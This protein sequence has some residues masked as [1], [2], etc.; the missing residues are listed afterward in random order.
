MAVEIIAT[1][2]S[3]GE[4]DITN[5]ELYKIISNF[6]IEVAKNSL[7]RKGVDLTNASE[8]AIFSLWVQQISG[9]KSRPFM[10]QA[11]EKKL[12]VE[13]LAYRASEQ[14]ITACGIEREKIEQVIFSTYSSN[15]VMPSPACTLINLLELPNASAITMN[16]AC[17]GFLDALIDAVI[18]IESGYFNTILVVASEQL[19]NKMNF[20]DPKSSVIFSD[21]AGCVIVSKTNKEGKGVLSFASGTSF[22]EQIY[23]ERKDSIYFNSGPLVKRNAVRTMFS[24]SEQSL[25]DKFSFS[26]I[27][28][29]IPHQANLRIIDEFE[30]KINRLCEES[31]SPKVIK[32]IEDL[33]NLS[34][35]TLPVALDLLV[36]KDYANQLSQ[37]NNKKMIFVSVGGGYTF[38]SLL[39]QF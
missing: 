22:S 6:E 2:S 24:I 8:E 36:K 30:R 18:R 39:Y 16:G 35:A 20:N 7:T 26:E 15:R 13:E 32:T 5:E 31:S 33:G 9:I 25:K 27:D 23:M 37:L 1:G 4:S 14:A 29:I 21:G 3:V 11:V 19:S 34:S 12:E 17:S 10:K 38:S 28:F